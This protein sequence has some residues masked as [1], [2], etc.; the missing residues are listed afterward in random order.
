MCS[1]QS[2][3]ISE[4]THA[5]SKSPQR[6]NI[7]LGFVP[8]N[9]ED[10]ETSSIRLYLVNDSEYTLMM[11][12]L[13]LREDEKYKLIKSSS[14]LPNAI[15]QIGSFSRLELPFLENLR[16][17]IIAHKNFGDWKLQDPI[18]RTIKT[19]LSKFLKRGSFKPT[20]ILGGDAILV[21]LTSRMPAEVESDK[22]QK[23]AEQYSNTSAKQ[24]VKDFSQKKQVRSFS[25]TPEMI[26]VDLH[27]EKLLDSTAGM[28]NGDIL[29]YQLDHLRSVISKYR[30]HTGIKIVFIHGKG[31]GILRTSILKEL[32]SM[33]LGNKVREASFKRYGSGA[34]MVIM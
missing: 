21:D 20:A 27:I 16:V 24:E 10:L 15:F 31:D 19:N 25:S 7:S 33:G 23:L 29:K 32:N 3:I 4:S 8:E 13:S 18:N 6:F 34:T 11:N 30:R 5:N 9:I 28:N 17:Q 26:E 2:K 22:I 12:L 14:I 1:K